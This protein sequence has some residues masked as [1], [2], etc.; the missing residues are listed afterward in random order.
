MAAGAGIDLHRPAHPRRGCARRR[1]GRLI[2]LEHGERELVPQ[3]ADRAFE[4]RRLAG[5]GRADE[6]EREDL[7]AEEPR[8]VLRASASFLARM[9]ASSASVVPWRSHGRL[10]GRGDRAHA[11]GRVDA[12]ADGCAACRRRGR[13]RA[14]EVRSRAGGRSADRARSV[15][16]RRRIRRSAHQAASSI[17]MLLIISSSPAAARRRRAARAG[18]IEIGVANSA[19]QSPAAR[20]AVDHA[21]VERRALDK[22]AFGNIAEAELDRLCHDAGELAD[23]DRHPAHAP[24][25]RG[26]AGNRDDVAR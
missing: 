11:H 7:A 9:R 22:G 2:A 16:L 5:A 14:P 18:G 15:S 6:V 13:A 21:D 23:L 26:L 24:A 3:I 25:V 12:R 8:A 1:R 19:A 4:Q 17:S 20:S 10:R